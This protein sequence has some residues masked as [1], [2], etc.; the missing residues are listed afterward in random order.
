MALAGYLDREAKR[1]HDESRSLL[2]IVSRNVENKLL[3]D[4]AFPD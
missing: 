1:K 3:R 4:R 2:W